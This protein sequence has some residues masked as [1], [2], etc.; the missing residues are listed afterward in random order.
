MGRVE[1]IEA[2]ARRRHLVED[3]GLDIGMP[4]VARLLPAVVV[5]HHEDQVGAWFTGVEEDREKQEEVE[6][7]FHPGEFL[8]RRTG[9]LRSRRSW[10]GD[11][12]LESE[13]ESPVAEP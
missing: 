8:I 11:R 12:R 6:E 2:Q 13:L 4:V 1:T 10:R 3:R 7:R 9:A 5:A